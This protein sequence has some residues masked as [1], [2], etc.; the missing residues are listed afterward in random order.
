MTSLIG[1]VGLVF[2]QRIASNAWYLI[3]DLVVKGGLDLPVP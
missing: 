2:G 3:D 1:E